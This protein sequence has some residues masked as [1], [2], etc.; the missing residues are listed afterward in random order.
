MGV[1][2]DRTSGAPG[3]SSGVLLKEV[4]TFGWSASAARSDLLCR[5]GTD[6]EKNQG[7]E[8]QEGGSCCCWQ[9][10]W[11][12]R[13]SGGWFQCVAKTVP[14]FTPLPRECGPGRKS[15]QRTLVPLEQ[16]SVRLWLGGAGP[17][18]QDSASFQGVID[19]RTAHF[20]PSAAKL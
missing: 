4:G 7:R 20:L 5:P 15:R 8:T 14:A 3:R 17:G 16:Q 1:G 13:G 18:E 6:F 19:G 10:C 2:R 11:R 12:L 9:G